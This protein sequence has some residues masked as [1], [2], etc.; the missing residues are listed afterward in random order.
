MALSEKIKAHEVSVTMTIDQWGDV[1]ASILAIY[2]MTNDQKYFDQAQM[3]NDQIL[4]VLNG[5]DPSYDN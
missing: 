5:L 2:T 4:V 1:A 3:I